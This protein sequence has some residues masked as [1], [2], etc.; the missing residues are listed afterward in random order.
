MRAPISYINMC[1]PALYSHWGCCTMI[2]ETRTP[3]PWM[4]RCAVQTR[5]IVILLLTYPQVYE[6]GPFHFIVR[7]LTM[8][9]NVSSTSTLIM[10]STE[11]KKG[12]KC[13]R[14][15]RQTSKNLFFFFLSAVS[16]HLSGDSSILMMKNITW[17]ITKKRILQCQSIHISNNG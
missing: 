17:H 14:C 13:R 15:F 9:F 5:V 6:K 8:C 2:R 7:R 10:L 16:R 1:R 11:T 4:Q 12:V 3:A